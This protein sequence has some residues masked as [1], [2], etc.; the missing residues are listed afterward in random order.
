MVNEKQ[1]VY[2]RRSVSPLSMSPS[3]SILDGLDFKRT[4]LLFPGKVLLKSKPL[5]IEMD[6]KIECYS[7]EAVKESYG[8][9]IVEWENV[10]NHRGGGPV[11]EGHF[12]P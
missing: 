4:L 1:K 7:G 8:S 3:K 11:G 10:S 2:H 12:S 9:N 6:D 5:I